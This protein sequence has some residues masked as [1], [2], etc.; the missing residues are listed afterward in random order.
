MKYGS[1]SVLS[2]SVS[3]TEEPCTF[4]RIVPVSGCV[5]PPSTAPRPVVGV[6]HGPQPVTE[7][8]L[9][10]RISIV[11]EPTTACV[12]PAWKNV[13]A[14]AS[15]S[16]WPGQLCGSNGSVVAPASPPASPPSGAAASAPPP[17]S[18]LPPPSA[19]PSVASPPL[20][21]SDAAPASPP[22]VVPP[23]LPPAPPSCPCAASAAP[24]PPSP[25]GEPSPP[26][27]SPAPASAPAPSNV[28][29]PPAHPTRS[30]AA[31]ATTIPPARVLV[32]TCIAGIYAAPAASF[33]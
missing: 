4:R 5:P 15:V 17:A 3:T 16:G 21:A 11:Y 8:Q 20:P 24:A 9:R 10:W 2:C 31:A 7:L 26:P 23:S 29:P 28:V 30:A 27:S 1:S 19:P 32:R 18:P 12:A 33:P 14:C 6:P 22:P 25:D 13:A